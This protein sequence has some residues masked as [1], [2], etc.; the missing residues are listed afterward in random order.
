MSSLVAR[1]AP[2]LILAAL[3]L[4]LTGGSAHAQGVQTACRQAV[5]MDAESHAFLYERAPD[6]LASPASLAKIMTAEILFGLIR[7]ARF[8]SATLMSF[9][10]MPGARAG[11][12]RAGQRC[13]RN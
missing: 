10:N 5:L 6:E 2:K 13:L 4:T 7:P 9:P 11:R 12:R 1:V 8:R 3:T